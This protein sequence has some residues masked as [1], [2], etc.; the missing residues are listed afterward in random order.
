MQK[1]NTQLDVAG[2]WK[3]PFDF[4]LCLGMSLNKDQVLCKKL[5][6]VKAFTNESELLAQY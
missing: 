4:K 6:A 1:N 2:C 3:L 5:R